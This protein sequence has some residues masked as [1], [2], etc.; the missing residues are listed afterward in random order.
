M[1]SRR[2]RSLVLVAGRLSDAPC[3]RGRQRAWASPASF[4]RASGR[5]GIGGHSRPAQPPLA[6]G[7]F[8]L[9]ISPPP[10]PRL[11][12]HRRGGLAFVSAALLNFLATCPN[13]SNSYAVWGFNVC[14]Y[15]IFNEHHTHSGM[16]VINNNAIAST[17]GNIPVHC[18]LRLS[19]SLTRNS[20]PHV[21]P[22]QD[23]A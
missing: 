15:V 7:F 1:A 14:D 21:S 11:P 2:P 19:Q 6:A 10:L 8:L 17:F 23:G 5:R 18:D 9:P 16:S 4:V 3:G 13:A 22:W 12:R 20:A